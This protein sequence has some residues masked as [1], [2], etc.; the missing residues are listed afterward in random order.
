[1]SWSSWLPKGTGRLSNMSFIRR[2]MLCII[3][4]EHAWEYIDT[5]SM[6]MDVSRR[7]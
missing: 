3:R 1:M 2:T 5:V 6:D 7:G 4:D